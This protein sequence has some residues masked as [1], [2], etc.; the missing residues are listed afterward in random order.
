M[1]PHGPIQ[2]VVVIFKELRKDHDNATESYFKSSRRIR[3]RGFG[4]VKIGTFE[5][6]VGADEIL[7]MDKRTTS[8]RLTRDTPE[9]LMHPVDTR[10]AEN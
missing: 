4:N 8:F 6:Y 2:R 10:A 9:S 7:A 1:A 5:Y 3:C